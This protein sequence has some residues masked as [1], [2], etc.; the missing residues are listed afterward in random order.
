MSAVRTHTLVIGA[1]FAGRTV[2][3]HVE[4]HLVIDRGEARGYHESLQR[5][6]DARS[7]ADARTRAEEIAYSSDLPWNQVPRLSDRCHSR[8]ALTLGGASNW[9]GGNVR[10]LPPAT[11][12]RRDADIAWPLSYA[13]MEPWYEKA[14]RRLNLSG[15]PAY[16]TAE[17][18]IAGFEHWRYALRPHFDAVGLSSVALNHGP[19][20]R[21]AQGTCSGR[22]NC[23]VCYDD[24]KARP[25]NVFE[26]H[27]ILPRT[28]CLQ[29][30]FDGARAVSAQ[31]YDGRD[32]FDIHFER[33]V[34]AA[35]GIESVALLKRSTL[36]PG[37]RSDA[38]GA[39]FQ[40][41]AH[42]HFIC[43]AKHPLPFGSS[44]GLAHVY[45]PEVAGEYHGIEISAFAMTHR[46]MT[47]TIDGIL[48]RDMLD[49]SDAPWDAL[50]RTVTIFCEL[51]MPPDA[52]LRVVLSEEGERVALDDAA[53]DEL[54]ARY[55]SVCVGV[56]ERLASHGLDVIA[57]EPHYRAG[58][59]GHHFCGTLN[60]GDGEHAVVDADARMIGTENVFVA[61]TALLPRSGGEGPTL[62]AMALAERLGDYLASVRHE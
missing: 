60:L 13:Q 18:T 42:V 48:F 10:R 36:P 57:V 45:L 46:P 11:F 49:G 3:D 41:H 51:E 43:R 1:G 19:P 24:A 6:T 47:E 27:N 32:L 17:H 7:D 28:M 44:A 55:D 4:D 21:T 52:R 14:E 15:D 12:E 35:N 37:V 53:Y 5:Y 29:L 8:Y 58:Y 16:S 56:M 62:T 61:G 2:A 26:P 33:C 30:E 20:T 34:V 39:Y 59:G 23:A 54:V 25:D 9:W 31:C 40:D 22:S 38:I 50:A